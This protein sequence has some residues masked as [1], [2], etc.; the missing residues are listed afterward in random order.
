M[1]SSEEVHIDEIRYIKE[2]ALWKQVDLKNEI[3]RLEFHRHISRIFLREQDK[4][5]EE[6]KKRVKELEWGICS[7]GGDIPSEPKIRKHNTEYHIH[8]IIV[9]LGSLCLC[10]IRKSN[11]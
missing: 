9:R 1:R 8:R 2:D 10:V 7:I 3:S 6:L 4:E 11:D 5:I